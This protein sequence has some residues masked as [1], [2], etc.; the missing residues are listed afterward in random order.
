MPRGWVN[1]DS[2]DLRIELKN[3]WHRQKSMVLSCQ[4][5]DHFKSLHFKNGSV[6][7]AASQAPEDKL[8]HQLIDLG[9][10]TKTQFRKAS[11][12]FHKEKSIGKNLLDMGLINRQE[13]VGGVRAQIFQIFSSCVN[14]RKGRFRIEEP[15]ASGQRVDLPLIFPEDFIRARMENEDK[16]WVSQRFNPDLDFVCE[17][18]PNSANP[19]EVKN[20]PADMQRVYACMDGRRDFKQMTFEADVDDFTLLKFI[21]ALKFLEYIHIRTE[22][23]A[24]PTDPADGTETGASAKPIDPNPAEPHGG[25]RTYGSP[26]IA[27]DGSPPRTNHEDLPDTIAMERTSF[28]SIAREIELGAGIGEPPSAA[29]GFGDPMPRDPDP[30]VKPPA[31]T[32]RGP[33]VPP[34]KTVRTALKNRKTTRFSLPLAGLLLGALLLAG[35]YFAGSGFRDAQPPNIRKHGPQT[36]A[37]PAPNGSIPTDTRP[38]ETEPETPQPTVES[39]ADPPEMS[40]TSPVSEPSPKT[41]PPERQPAEPAH[42]TVPASEVPRPAEATPDSRDPM[43]LAVAGKYGRAAQLW[44]NLYQ[45]RHQEFTLAIFMLCARKSLDKVFDL[46]QKTPV[47]ILPRSYNGTLCYWVCWGSYPSYREAV[48]AIPQL[49]ASLTDDREGIAA[50]RIAELLKQ[51]P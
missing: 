7:F 38:H 18:Q 16:D 29:F 51:S 10:L 28:A 15:P 44:K 34:T 21:H 36:A 24:E 6:Y 42:A 49:P 27:E 2:Y 4:I 23:E 13:L 26:P 1:F 5:R 41:L 9:Y 22:G 46:E 20:L 37:S 50:Y 35:F 14:T 17:I 43:A 39:P 11:G 48:F 3:L 19:L 33:E 12:T 31:E 45:R 32:P 30:L 25:P 8:H 47:F 40:V